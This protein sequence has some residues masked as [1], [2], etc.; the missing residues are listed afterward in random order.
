MTN[1]V[2]YTANGTSV[3]FPYPFA[4]PAATALEVRIGDV[5]QDVGFHISGAGGADGGMVVFDSPPAEGSDISLRYLGTVSVS[6]DDATAGHLVDK[7]VAGANI[8]FDT[9]VEDGGIQ[10]LRITSP[11]VT[12]ALEKAANLS[13]LEDKAAA[14]ANLGVYSKTETDA[15]DQAVRDA[16]LLKNGNLAGLADVAAA[17]TN[18]GVYSK[19][20]TEAVAQG[21]RDAALL[22][23]NNLS[24]L[25]DKPAARTNLGVYSTVET[26]ATIATATGQ[27]SGEVLHRSQNL[28][29]VAD[30]AVAR[31]NLE[32]YSKSETDGA[33]LAKGQNLADLGNTAQARSNLGLDQVAYLN[34]AQDWTKPQRS[35]AVQAASVGGATVLDFAQYQNFNLTLTASITFANPT[36]SAALIGQKGTIGIVPAGFAIAG[37][38]SLWKRVG[39]VGAPSGITGIGRI[40]YH[41]RA[42]DRIEY[43]YNDV[44]A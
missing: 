12:D 19:P 23:A 1:K 16:A 18:L 29:D 13:D 14:R 30:K 38:G 36:L 35:Q 10:R 3:V 44:E 24:D 15:L 5:V 42:L 41:I 40:D 32:I 4:I 27:L 11:D 22:K 37:M 9:V 20:E 39:E 31:G 8:V 21:V 7:L 33:Y 25:T 17:R 2:D 28:D 6:V 34:A 43:A 26:D